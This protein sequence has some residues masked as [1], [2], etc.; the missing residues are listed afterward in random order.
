MLNL[1]SF[2]LYK[3]KYKIK[4]ED[5]TAKSSFI[6]FYQMCYRVDLVPQ[7]TNFPFSFSFHALLC[8]DTSLE[9]IKIPL[10]QNIELSDKRTSP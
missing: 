8:F 7:S 4:P 9:L 10:S 3:V 2:R 6:V 1:N 5:W